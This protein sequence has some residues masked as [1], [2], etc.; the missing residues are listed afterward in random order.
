MPPNGDWFFIYLF[1]PHFLPRRMLGPERTIAAAFGVFCCISY[2]CQEAGVGSPQ[3]RLE[4]G[5]K[6]TWGHVPF[7]KPSL[8]QLLSWTP[9]GGF[10]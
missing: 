4:T 5:V 10:G 9:R 7:A 2:W 8:G 6:A 1:C 3:L